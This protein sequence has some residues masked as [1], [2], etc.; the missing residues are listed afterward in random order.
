VPAHDRV[1]CDQQPQ[2]WRRAFGITPN[3]AANTARSAQFSFG[4]RG[5]RR[6]R[7]ASWW[8]RIKISAV[9]HASSRRDSRS[10]EATRVIRRK[11][12]R[13]H[14]LVI[15]TGGAQER[16]TLLVRAMDEILGTHRRAGPAGRHRRNL[17]ARENRLVRIMCHFM[18]RPVEPPS[19]PVSEADVQDE[20]PEP[21]VEYSAASPVHDERQ[22]DDGQDY[23]DHPEENTMMPGMAY[24][25]TVLALATATSYPPTPDLFGG[26]I[27][28]RRRQT[29]VDPGRHH[30]RAAGETPSARRCSAI[31][32]L[33]RAEI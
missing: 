24:P 32:R 33:R 12:N 23:H 31:P 27:P 4:R 5:C 26:C 25:A 18:R 8:R 9:F 1:R 14:M 28:G 16:A 29:L 7:T 11:T 2:P 30:V 3:R 17:G 13:R 10:H 21:Q 6:C 19:G 15:I 22:Q 20:V